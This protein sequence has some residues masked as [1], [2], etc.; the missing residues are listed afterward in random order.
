MRV[1]LLVGSDLKHSTDRSNLLQI[2]R[3][4]LRSS[5]FH[6]HHSTSQTS[7][8]ITYGLLTCAICVFRFSFQPG[9]R[10]FSGEMSP[11]F[12]FDENA[13]LL[14]LL[15]QTETRPRF[16]PRC[17]T[18]TTTIDPCVL[19]VFPRL[20]TTMRSLHL[21]SWQLIEPTLRSLRRSSQVI[22]N[23]ILP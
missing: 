7:E 11:I 21:A 10:V 12:P 4:L 1:F 22:L 8:I 13:V 19:L 16:R 9:N 5:T 15:Q 6:L 23:S 17:R 18:N 2:P 3:P 20:G 14:T